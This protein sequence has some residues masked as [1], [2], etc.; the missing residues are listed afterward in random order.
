LKRGDIVTVAAGHGF[1]GKP[2]PALVIQA[3]EYEQISTVVVLLFTSELIETPVSRPRFEPTPENGL[4][5]TSDLMT[6]IFVTARRKNIGGKI[7]ELNDEAMALVDRALIVF[8]G[9]SG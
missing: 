9:L 2:R 6:D 1:G 8:L 5:S 4:V 3:D 7:G